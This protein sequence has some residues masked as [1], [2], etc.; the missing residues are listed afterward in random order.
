MDEPSF[1][2]TAHR[3][4]YYFVGAI[5]LPAPPSPGVRRNP[6]AMAFAAALRIDGPVWIC[7]R[8][9][10]RHGAISSNSPHLPFN[11]QRMMKLQGEFEHFKNHGRG[12]RSNKK[13]RATPRE[14]LKFVCFCKA[15]S[16]A[17]VLVAGAWLSPELLSQN[18]T[19][20][21]L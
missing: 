4:S 16:L 2:C 19:A 17:N 13:Q 9:L 11:W 21:G 12:R 20:G 8:K 18:S 3:T 1:T 7:Q 15:R 10:D 5:S 14:I 6:R